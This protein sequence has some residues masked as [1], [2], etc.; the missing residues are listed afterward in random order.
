MRHNWLTWKFYCFSG[1]LSVCIAAG[2]ILPAATYAQDFDNSS[3][4]VATNITLTQDVIDKV[5]TINEFSLNVKM[6]PQERQEFGSIMARYWN[7]DGGKLQQTVSQLLP[8]YDQL[9][10]MPEKTR[11][12]ARRANTLTFLLGLEQN[13]QAKDEISILM[14]RAY[15]RVHPPL[16]AEVPFVSAEVAD[17]FIDA[18][19]F[20]NEVKSGRKAPTMSEAALAKTR[21]GIAADFARMSEANR[22]QFVE[23]M[24]RTTNLMLNWDKMESWEQLLTRAEVGAP[25]SPQEQQMVQQI[26]QQLN[27]HS[28]QMMANELKFIAQNQQTIMGS[29]PY[30]NP[31]SQAWEQ[32]GGIVTEYR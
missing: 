10:Q 8:A 24:Q 17:A 3:E 25:L 19:V 27:G 5:I 18:Y 9:M 7:A 4:R 22:N 14:L 16:L 6:T 21:L 28:M 12:L 13:A 1:L 31:S 2:T 23:Q 30:W 15:R 26:Q 29:A 20:I 32:K 11:K